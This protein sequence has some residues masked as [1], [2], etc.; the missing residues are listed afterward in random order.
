L[1]RDATFKGVTSVSGELK[2]IG[3]RSVENVSIYIPPGVQYLIISIMPLIEEDGKSYS[4]IS[5]R[6]R[7]GLCPK[8]KVNAR[9]LTL[10]MG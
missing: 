1:V 10:L 2:K 9:M 4:E 7:L 3:L 6:P 8:I 5:S